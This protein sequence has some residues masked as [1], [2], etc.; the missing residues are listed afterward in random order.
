MT[1]ITQKIANFSPTETSSL[2]LIVGVVLA[3]AIAFGFNWPF[4]FIT[5][6]F[7]AKFL[8]NK[9]P[10][11]PLKKLVSIFLILTAA[12]VLGGVLTRFLTPFPAVFILIITLLI[13]W[14]SYW[15]NSGGNEVIVTMLLVGLTAIP[16]LGI[17]DQRLAELFT[18]GFLFSCFVS[19]VL[20]MVMHELI[21]DKQ[22]SEHEQLS[23]PVNNAPVELDAEGLPL[24]DKAVRVK[25]A[26]LSTVMIMP[27]VIYFLS[28]Q[29]TALLVLIF[30]SL[31]AQKPDLVA[32]IKGSKALLVG[33]IMGGLIAIALYNVLKVAPTFSFLLLLF[34]LIVGYLAK[35]IF[36]EKR[37]APL[38]A[39]ALGTTIILISSASAGASDADEKFYVRIMQIAFAC[40]YIVFATVLANPLLQKL[41]APT[42]TKT[43]EPDKPTIKA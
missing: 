5:P 33:N 27:V 37:T 34:A 22:L 20:V 26:L 4:A 43:I 39:M 1:F 40:S 24:P 29:S 18:F 14:I 12:I 28:F 3:V 16:V 17:I 38:Y 9:K 10:K 32:G 11:L 23:I 31:M 42:V 15:N 30:I 6:V 21:P 41:S 35:H 19:L 8:S 36:S 25:L 2:R 13:F 7:V